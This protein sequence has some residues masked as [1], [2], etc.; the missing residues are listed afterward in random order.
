VAFWLYISLASL[1]CCAAASAAAAF[2]CLFALFCCDIPA[3]V[4]PAPT[5]ADNAGAAATVEAMA[6]PIAP[7][8]GTATGILISF[9]RFKQITNFV[10]FKSKP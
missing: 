6:D 5:T 8:T 7:R 10:S 3:I 9:A 1:D 2:A 4:V